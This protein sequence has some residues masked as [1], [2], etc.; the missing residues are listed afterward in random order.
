MLNFFEND[1]RFVMKLIINTICLGLFFG[2][3]FASVCLAA[4]ADNAKEKANPKALL[5]Q[6]ACEAAGGEWGT[7]GLVPK[8]RC[9]R[10]TSDAGKV[11]NDSS[12]CESECIAQLSENEKREVNEKAAKGQ[13]IAK[14][15]KCSKLGINVG[16]HAF[17]HKGQVPGIVC[18]D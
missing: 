4:P 3:C 15:G 16:C 11:C 18:V 2:I 14:Q 5:T 1:R 13:A 10:H 6:E 9:N 12:E 17:V 8:E 7:F